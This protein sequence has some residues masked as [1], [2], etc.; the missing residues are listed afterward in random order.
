LHQSCIVA[1]AGGSAC[2]CRR[3]R[4]RWLLLLWLLLRHLQ[5]LRLLYRLQ[6][7]LRL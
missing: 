1:A 5:L 7:K 2:P 4:S 3:L 6:D